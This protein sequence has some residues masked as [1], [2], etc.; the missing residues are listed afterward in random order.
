LHSSVSLKCCQALIPK[1]FDMLTLCSKF[2]LK[3]F[4]IFNI[5]IFMHKK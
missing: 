2:I 5:L 1:E 3:I 4:F